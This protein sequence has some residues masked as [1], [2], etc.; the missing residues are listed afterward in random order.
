[1]L[2]YFVCNGNERKACIETGFAPS[3]ATELF[4]KQQ[5]K[6][7]IEKLRPEFEKELIQKVITERQ[8]SRDFLDLNLYE[9][10]SERRNSLHAWR[11][12]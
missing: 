7:L 5:V 8:L 11:R 2:N 10:Y 4:R 12:G 1:M 9:R 6:D 3:Y